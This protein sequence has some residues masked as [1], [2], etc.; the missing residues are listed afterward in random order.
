M[1]NSDSNQLCPATASIFGQP[2]GAMTISMLT[3]GIVLA[4]PFVSYALQKNNYGSLLPAML[5]LVIGW[6]AL[7]VNE[8]FRRNSLFVIAGLILI[9]AVFVG[10]MTSQ[11]V[12]VMI[13][14]VLAWFFGRTLFCP[15][16]LIE[17]FVK[18][19][20]SDIPKEVLDY[21]RQL[22]AVWAGLF[23]AIVIVSVTFMLT[24]HDWYLT[25]LHGVIVWLLMAVLALA[26]HFYRLRR[27]PFM[28]DQMPSIRETFQSAIKSKDQ[29]W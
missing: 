25:L 17:R 21:C 3:T 1:K 14:S 29:L 12:P 8:A 15:P 11:L 5:A 9:G 20:F 6:R 26:E 27:F 4:Y 16:S 19:Q 24:G 28:K 22:T 10:S 23:V 7:S 13:Y 18:L 2:P